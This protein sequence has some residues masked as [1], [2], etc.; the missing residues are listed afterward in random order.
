MKQIFA[1]IVL[2]L[3]VM[4]AQAAN[5]YVSTSGS[6]SN[7]GTIGSPFLTIQHG[8]LAMSCGDVLNVRGGTYV[9]DIGGIYGV[10]P[11]CASYAS[12]ITIQNYQSETVIITNSGGSEIFQLVTDSQPTH[13]DFYYIIRASAVGKLVLDGM[14]VTFA[15]GGLFGDY[16]RLINLEVKNSTGSGILP[17]GDHWDMWN[18]HVHHN[19]SNDHDHGIYETG[20]FMDVEGG[21]YDHNSGYGIQFQGPS[22]SDV[23]AGARI[24]DNT[25]GMTLS[26][27]S[28]FLAY[29]NSIY[30][31]PAAGLDIAASGFCGDCQAYQNTLYGNGLGIQVGNAGFGALRA[32]VKNNI[33][34]NN[35][36]T[37]TDGGQQSVISNNITIDPMFTDAVNGDFTLK[38]SSAAI[39]AGVDLSSLMISGL[40]F[41][42][43]GTAYPNPPPAGNHA[44]SITPI[45]SI[46][47]INPVSLA[48]GATSQTV[49]LTTSNVILDASSAVHITC[50]GV[51][52]NSSS[53]IDSNNETANVTV[54]GGATVAPCDIS[55]TTTG[56]P[57]VTR[58]GGFSV[59]MSGS[60]VLVSSNPST[61]IQGQTGVT[62]NITATG[63]HFDVTTAPTFSPSTGIS[64][65]SFAF[66]D[67]TH[68]ILTA[69]FDLTTPVGNVTVTLTTG[70][71][72]AIGTN[73]LAVNSAAACTN[74]PGSIGP[75]T[76]QCTIHPVD[77]SPLTSV[78][79]PDSPTATTANTDHY[80]LVLPVVGCK[81]S[82]CSATTSVP[83]SGITSNLGLTYAKI[84]NSA[85]NLLNQIEAWIAPIS[86]AGIENTTAS[87]GGATTYYSSSAWIELHGLKTSS[88]FDVSGNATGTS[89]TPSVSTSGATTVVGDLVIACIVSSGSP[90]INAGS[91]YTLIY[92][93]SQEACEYKVAGGMATQTATFD[94]PNNL[95]N[96]LI[97]ALKP[98][99]STPPSITSISP[100]IGH[101]GQ[102]SLALTINGANT[103][104]VDGVSFPS[105]DNQGGIN[106]D[107]F[108]CSDFVTCVWT[109]GIAAGASL[110]TRDVSVITGPEIATKSGALI[111]IP[112]VSSGRLRRD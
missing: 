33:S 93:S 84:A 71:E 87:W 89:T 2:L 90:S 109:F 14:N 43:D 94:T 16:V 74:F 54:S 51:T 40:A 79:T 70:A 81:D 53:N 78:V 105:M 1:L 86:S 68:G 24:H 83:V 37:I 52:V 8:L 103:H 88:P 112:G 100:S 32:I 39:G 3:W 29:N 85:T 17:H 4:P 58:T 25:S 75:V 104:F 12:S 110:T 46:D 91:G 97:F 65:A 64:N 30:N 55:I 107:S 76:G 63:S 11:H 36:T 82:G 57:T 111:I 9:D 50:S 69:D 44:P 47:I 62:F 77:F 102:V 73:L 80:A 7:P 67:A 27:G 56:Q 99:T 13:R 49:S 6:N 18:L 5:L 38:P 72:A 101:T 15:I 31:N 42:I 45:A 59:M 92:N 108:T 28:N 10:V 96:A 106:T 21:E 35:G 61:V 60:V 22:A 41:D 20:D 95:F 48:Q 19:G 66:S 34:F 98:N 26:G 23:V